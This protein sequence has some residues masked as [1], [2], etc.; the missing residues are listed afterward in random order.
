MAGEQC[1]GQGEERPVGPGEVGSGRTAVQNLELV[2][3]HDDLDVLLEPAKTTNPKEFDGATDETEEKREGH[4]RR[5]SPL[6]SCLVKLGFEFLHPTPC[7]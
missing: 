2:A 1:P 6:R 7:R 5:G 3:Q 4:G